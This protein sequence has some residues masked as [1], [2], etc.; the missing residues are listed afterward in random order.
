[1]SEKSDA[2]IFQIKYPTSLRKD[3]NFSSNSLVTFTIG[4]KVTVIN[5]SRDWL[6]VRSHHNGPSGYIR[7][8]FA[9]PVD[10]AVNR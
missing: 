2:K 4:T 3:P 10:V 7:K 6:E 5:R 9:I 8:E 1:M